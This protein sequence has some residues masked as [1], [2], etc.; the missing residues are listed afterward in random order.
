MF[1]SLSEDRHFLR[2]V[3]TPW[4]GLEPLDEMFRL[5]TYS[6]QMFCVI[7]NFVQFHCARSEY[8]VQG[9]RSHYE[10]KSIAPESLSLIFS[11]G[12]GPNNMIWLQDGLISWQRDRDGDTQ[13]IG[14]EAIQKFIKSLH[15][16]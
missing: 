10:N 2:Q 3:F 11:R 15:A 7:L 1:K 5:N 13:L 6:V 14:I 4:R 8:I 16:N 12:D 9:Y